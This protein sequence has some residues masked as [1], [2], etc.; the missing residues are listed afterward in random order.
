MVTV[1]ID[2]HKHVHVKR[3]T[4]VINQLEA[5]LHVWLDHTPADL[6]R[7]KGLTT[8][9]ARLGTAPLSTHA[10]QALTAM[11]AEIA[12]IADLNRRVHDL[13]TTIKDLV[14]PLG[15]STP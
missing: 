12:E 7:T 4:M 11:I 8:L 3:R 15:P 6:S 5:Q 10:R 1:G 13:D 14:S 2:P 9:T